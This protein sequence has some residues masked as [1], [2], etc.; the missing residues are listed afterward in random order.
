MNISSFKKAVTKMIST[1][2]KEPDV[3]VKKFAKDAYY[4][5]L[6]LGIQSPEGILKIHLT[7]TRT[8]TCTPEHT[9]LHPGIAAHSSEHLYTP[10]HLCRPVCTCTHLR[11][12]KITR[13]HL[14][15]LSHLCI[16]QQA[17]GHWQSFKKIIQKEERRKKEGKSRSQNSLNHQ[18]IKNMCS[19]QKNFYTIIGSVFGFVYQHFLKQNNVGMFHTMDILI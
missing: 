14:C 2:F 5:S 1:Y 11:T 3:Q 7:H 16:C 18:R 19:L 15:Y 12:L 17:K 9:C 4:N 10:A 8:H 13:T 6:M